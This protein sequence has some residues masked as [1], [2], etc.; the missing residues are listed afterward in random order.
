MNVMIYSTETEKPGPPKRQGITPIKKFLTEVSALCPAQLRAARRSFVCV[1]NAFWIH[2]VCWAAFQTKKK[3]CHQKSKLSSDI[4]TYDQI[5]IMFISKMHFP[6]KTF[7]G[8]QA[9]FH[10]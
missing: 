8:T 6:Q 1:L 4:T 10:P 3:V 7:Q 2:T 5:I 9:K